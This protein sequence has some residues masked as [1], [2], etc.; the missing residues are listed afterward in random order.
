MRH[1]RA[2]TMNSK[3]VVERPYHQKRSLGATI[4]RS[5]HRAFAEVRRTSGMCQEL[6]LQIGGLRRFSATEDN[7]G[8]VGR[9]RNALNQH[10]PMTSGEF[11]YHLAVLRRVLPPTG[12]LL[13]LGGAMCTGSQW[14]MLNKCY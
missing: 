2:F 6:P 11:C 14:A 8:I 12:A 3:G 5:A 4:Q 7:A 1:S 9:H 13:F 10:Q